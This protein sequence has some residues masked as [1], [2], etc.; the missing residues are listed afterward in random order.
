MNFWL[1]DKALI[2]KKIKPFNVL[3][4][5]QIYLKST[6]YSLSKNICFANVSPPQVPKI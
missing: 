2:A 1:V 3:Q 5:L 6:K 4:V